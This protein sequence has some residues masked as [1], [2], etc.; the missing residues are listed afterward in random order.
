MQK[1]T[2]DI[3]QAES[4]VHEFTYTDSKSVL[5]ADILKYF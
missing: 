4:I 3:K 5:H 2:A 1:R